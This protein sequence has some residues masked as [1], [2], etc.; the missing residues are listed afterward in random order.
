MASAPDLMNVSARLYASAN[1]VSFVN[2][3]NSACGTLS[4]GNA[5]FLRAR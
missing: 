1:M 3:V 4:R 2:S 5:F